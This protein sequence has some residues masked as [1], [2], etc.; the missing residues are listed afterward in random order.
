MATSDGKKIFSLP[1][2]HS[3]TSCLSSVFDDYFEDPLSAATKFLPLAGEFI[4]RISTSEGSV[5]LLIG[6]QDFFPSP[7]PPRIWS[8][9]PNALKDLAFLLFI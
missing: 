1:V 8:P 6:S 2:V 3:K 5:R 7:Q 4:C 9:T